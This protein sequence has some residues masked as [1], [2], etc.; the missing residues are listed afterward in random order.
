MRL[1]VLFP[2]FNNCYFWVLHSRVLM[3]N[4]WPRKHKSSHICYEPRIWQFTSRSCFPHMAVVLSLLHGYTRH[5]FVALLCDIWISQSIM[6]N[7]GIS[8]TQPGLPSCRA[9]CSSTDI[10]WLFP[11]IYNSPFASDHSVYSRFSMLLHLLVSAVVK[12]LG[13]NLQ[14]FRSC[15][16]SQ[17][18]IYMNLG[19]RSG[20]GDMPFFTVTYKCI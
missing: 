9:N 17:Q 19:L 16:M 5:F 18:I 1:P 8:Q 11:R 2:L 14:L 7:R 3:H 15:F 12:R 10:T 6:T 4:L 20:R 13:F